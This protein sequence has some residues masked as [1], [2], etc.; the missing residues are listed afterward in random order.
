MATSPSLPDVRRAVHRE[1]ALERQQVVEDGED[2]LLDLAGVARP[3]DDPELLPEV[4]DDERLRPRP[5]RHRVRLESG[6]GDDREVGDVAPRL[7]HRRVLEEHRAGEEAVPGLLGDDPDRQPVLG[8]GPAVD[9]LHEDVAALEVAAEPGVE[10]AEALGVEGP[11]VLAPPHVLLGRLLAHHELVGG[12]AGGVLAGVHHERALV[13]ELPLGA[14][15]RLLVE[16]GGGQV[17][18]DPAEVGEPVVLEAVEARHRPRLLHRGRLD[19]EVDVHAQSLTS[20]RSPRK[21]SLGAW[22]SSAHLM[23]SSPSMISLIVPQ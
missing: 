20:L 18:V 8:I 5:V 13:A 23:R 19:V 4:E 16:G 6:G 15:D 21:S 7:L 14:V 2:R 1:H 22:G 12:G 17:P 11:V 10:R 3:P 9:V